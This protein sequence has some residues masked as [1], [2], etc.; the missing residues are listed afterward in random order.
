MNNT[1]TKLKQLPDMPKKGEVLAMYGFSCQS[2]ILNTINEFFKESGRS[3]HKQTLTKPIFKKIIEMYGVP[4]G[5]KN[6]DN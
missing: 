5:Y 4:R 6:F 1:D 2:E 3:K